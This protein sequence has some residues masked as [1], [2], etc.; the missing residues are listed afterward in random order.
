MGTVTRVLWSGYWGKKIEDIKSCQPEVK[1]SKS[2]KRMP[3]KDL[4]SMHIY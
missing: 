2:D 4:L 1:E 3:L